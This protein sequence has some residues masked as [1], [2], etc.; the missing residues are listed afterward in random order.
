VTGGADA[1]LRAG[2]A[3]FGFD[4]TAG[5]GEVGLSAAGFAGVCA[6]AARAIETARSM[7]KPL[8]EWRRM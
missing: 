7:K 2:A 6:D 3:G 5:P 8:G 1:A 4:G